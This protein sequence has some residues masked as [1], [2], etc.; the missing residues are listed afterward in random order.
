MIRKLLCRL[1]F[2]KWEK[3]VYYQFLFGWVFE[4]RCKHCGKVKE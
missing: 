4:K 2:H 3:F 1:G